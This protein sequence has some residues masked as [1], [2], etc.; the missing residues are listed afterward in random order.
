MRYLSYLDLSNNGIGEIVLPGG[1]KSKDNDNM[2]PWVG[3]DGQEQKQKP[4]TP[5]GIITLADPIRCCEGLA[6]VNVLGNNIGK[7]Q[8]SQLQ[9]IMSSQP[10]LVSLCGIADDA[11]E[12][13]LSGLGL[14]ADDASILASELPDKGRLSELNLRGNS[15][16]SEQRAVIDGICSAKRVAVLWEAGATGY[17]GGW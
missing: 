10:N 1:W 17:Q 16:P 2:P 4:G 6:I 5:E 13:D 3:P 8:L 7:E 12:I 15:I 11:T 9:E 14:D